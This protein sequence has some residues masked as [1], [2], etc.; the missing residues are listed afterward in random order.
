MTR[1]TAI[2]TSL[3]LGAVSAPVVAGESDAVFISPDPAIASQWWVDELRLPDAWHFASGKGVVIA[4]CDTGFHVDEPDLL[5]NLDR[6]RARDLAD[7]QAP[8]NVADGSFMF[9]GTASAALMVAARDG[10][11]VNGIAYN[12]RLVPLQYYNFDRSIDDYTK[13]E[14][15]AR[16]IAHAMTM[17]DVRILLLQSSATGG[18]AEREPASRDLIREAVRRGIVVVVAAGNQASELDLEDLDDTGSV[19]VGAL[20]QDGR[21]AN[22][23]N[24]GARVTTSAFGENV[25]TLYGPGG[26]LDAFGGTTAAAAQ[27]A[28]TIALMIEVNPHLTPQAVRD[29]L[30]STRQETNGNYRV[31]GRLDVI[32]A[33]QAALDSFRYSSSLALP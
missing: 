10:W 33:L 16:C 1:I 2:L 30:E 31:G 17:R 23:S 28:A 22:Y 3:L 9:H 4:D 7:K 18:T 32:A 19:I 13:E 11:G 20:R 6:S 24:Y 21:S 27:V 29:I 5:P 26:R 14:G 25:L 12:A 15:T 8:Q